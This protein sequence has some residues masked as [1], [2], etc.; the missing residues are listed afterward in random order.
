MIFYTAFASP[1]VSVVIQF[2]TAI[3]LT[4]KYND[5]FFA[6]NIDFADSTIVLFSLSINLFCSTHIISCLIFFESK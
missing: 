6:C 4:Y 1:N 2:L 3:A 5:N